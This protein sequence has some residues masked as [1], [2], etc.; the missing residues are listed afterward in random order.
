VFAWGIGENEP[1]IRE[2]ICEGFGFLGITLHRSRNAKNAALIS[3]D[4]SRVSMRVIRTNEELL[5]PR[6]VIRVLKLGTSL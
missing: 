6:S 3:T 2:R 1:K 5:I 4:V